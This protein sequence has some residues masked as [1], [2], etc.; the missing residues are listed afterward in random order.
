MFW[1][2]F[3]LF[4]KRQIKKEYPGVAE[5]I[6]DFLKNFA[7]CKNEKEIEKALKENKIL[8]DFIN[9][10]ILT[11]NSDTLTQLL[12]SLEKKEQEQ[13]QEREQEREKE[14]TAFVFSNFSPSL[15]L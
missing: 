6:S 8:F 5:E 15:K 3:L 7:D 12:F 1:I 14:E 10:Y 2:E 4:L 13:K 9:N 11:L